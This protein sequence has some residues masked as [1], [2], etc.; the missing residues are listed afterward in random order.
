MQIDF[1]LQLICIYISIYCLFMHII[2]IIKRF[3]KQ[4][5]SALFL[6]FHPLSVPIAKAK[7]IS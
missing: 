3:V 7:R 6:W 2:C 5:P 1:I 4:I